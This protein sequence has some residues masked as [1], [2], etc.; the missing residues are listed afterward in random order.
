MDPVPSWT[1]LR[2]LGST[3]PPST[4]QNTAL[5]RLVGHFQW[6]WVGMVVSD[7]EMG[8]QGGQA[9]RRGIEDSGSCVAFMEQVNL[10]YSKEKVHRIA[11]IIRGHSSNVIIFHSPEVHL[12]MLLQTLYT[13]KVTGKVWVFTAAVTITPGL[14]DNQ[15]WRILNGSLGIAPYTD[16]M[17][18]FEEFLHSLEP[19]RYPDDIFIQ[20][21][22]KKAFYCDFKEANRT[23]DVVVPR[24]EGEQTLCSG[25]EAL[26]EKVMT[27]F[28]MNDLSYTYQSYTAVY[29]F[30]H[31][32]NILINCTSGR[33]LVT[34]VA[35]ADINNY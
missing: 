16:H 20:I 31:A 9:I 29:A 21:L 30:A 7:D 25:K 6:A 19:M 17:I 1:T 14:L 13:L 2:P 15:A 10:R 11:E 32:L 5:A 4:F 8:L 23:R 18:G 26:A 27:L 35:C 12:K 22:W 34:K 3:L 28:E 33:R 24:Q